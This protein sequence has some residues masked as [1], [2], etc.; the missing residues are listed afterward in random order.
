MVV[1]GKTDKNKLEVI[2][3]P[4]GSTSEQ[5]LLWLFG[6]VE[7]GDKFLV[8]DFTKK[9]I[10]LNYAGRYIITSLGLEVPDT[11][12]DFLNELI[13]R[14]GNT[15]PK[16]AE[17]S[18]YARS[19]L[20]HVSPIEEP[21][22]TLMVWLEREELL[23]RTLEKQ[24]VE[25]KLRQGFG[26]SGTDVDNFISFSLSVQ[27][28]RKSRAGYAFENHLAQIFNKHDIM[29]SKGAKTEGNS[30]P[31]FLFPGKTYYDN[32]E[33]STSLLT[34]LG[35]KTSAKERW[36][37]VLTEADRIASK[38]L[39]TLEPAIS[40]NQTDEMIKQNLQLVLP[41]PIMETYT[42]NQ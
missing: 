42:E 17:F 19:T 40:K 37:Q 32:L 23:F 25:E 29:Y 20:K 36:R 33:F 9:D 35:L 38:H 39:L 11:S 13:R 24:I 16:T 7:M 31:D 8:R 10:Q 4:Q 5:Q 41:Q 22:V 27:N 18:A 6:L 15:F 26:E 2:I 12:P 21:D 28:R 34:M 1:I 14:F 3:A 30:K